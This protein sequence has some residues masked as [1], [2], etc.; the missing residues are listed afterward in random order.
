MTLYQIRTFLV[1]TQDLGPG[2]AR[3]LSAHEAEAMQMRLQ[4]SRRLRGL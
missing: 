1:G 2:T 3:N 4:E